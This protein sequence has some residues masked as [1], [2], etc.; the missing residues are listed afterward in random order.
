MNATLHRNK[1]PL[2]CA[3]LAYHGGH[4]MDLINGIVAAT[5]ALLVA[6]MIAFVR[7]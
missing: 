7:E 2:R 1:R 3:P 6:K 4:P 5:I